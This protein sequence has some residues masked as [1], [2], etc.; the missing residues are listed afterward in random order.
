MSD[1]K[2]TLTPAQV[3][4]AGLTDWHLEGDRLRARFRTGDFASGLAFVNR[5]GAAAEEADHH[6]DLTLTYPEVAVA[7][8]SH[9]VDGITS[10]DVDLAR[11]VSALA[12]E[13]GISAAG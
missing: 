4:D 10:R 1:P 6:P 11:R 5:I 3:A 7:M 8:W 13:L 2:Q 9:D 12:T